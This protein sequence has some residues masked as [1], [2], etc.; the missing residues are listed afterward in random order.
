MY[1]IFI[2]HLQL[3]AKF[4]MPDLKGRCQSANG[5]PKHL[6]HQITVNCCTSVAAL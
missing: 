1:K 5:I 2:K 3:N 4:A 6:Q